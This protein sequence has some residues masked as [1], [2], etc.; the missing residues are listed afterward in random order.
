MN[1]IELNNMLITHLEKNNLPFEG[2]IIDLETTGSFCN[3]YDSR[4]YHKIK[5][6]LFGYINKNELKIICAKKEEDIETLKT[7]TLEIITDLE[8]P[9][10]AFNCN[11]EMGVLFHSL[12]LKIKFEGDLMKKRVPGIKWEKK[13][14]ATV[15]LNISNYDD[16]FNGDGYK[17]SLNWMNGE[18]EKAITHNRS[19]LLKERDILLKRGYRQPD[20]FVFSSIEQF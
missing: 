20:P 3:F 9:F 16:P 10:F 1:C 6:A 15:E 12:G 2:T 7:Q 8:K 11:F 14:E 4:R 18:W 5:P 13:Q 19:C 17:C